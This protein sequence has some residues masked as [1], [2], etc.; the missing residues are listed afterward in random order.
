MPPKTNW[1]MEIFPLVFEADWITA[2]AAW[3]A[4]LGPSVGAEG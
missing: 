4:M 2:A 3:N 1:E